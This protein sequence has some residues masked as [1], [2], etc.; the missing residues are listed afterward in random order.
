LQTT[1]RAMGALGKCNAVYNAG[2]PFGYM[3]SN[4][5]HGKLNFMCATIGFIAADK[6]IVN[7][8]DIV[9]LLDFLKSFRSA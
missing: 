2:T 8:F 6:L 9:G 4:F 3:L 1:M 7:L 5:L